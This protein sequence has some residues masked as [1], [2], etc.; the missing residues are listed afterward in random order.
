MLHVVPRDTWLMRATHLTNS[1]LDLV[2]YPRIAFKFCLS[3][4]IKAIVAVA[5]GQRL[6]TGDSLDGRFHNRLSREP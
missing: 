1:H 6:L 3:S 4:V 2:D 5:L